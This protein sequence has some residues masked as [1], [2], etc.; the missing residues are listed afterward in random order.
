MHSLEFFEFILRCEES[1]NVLGEDIFTKRMFFP[2]FNPEINNWRDKK[3]LILKDLVKCLHLQLIIIQSENFQ[4]SQTDECV[5]KF[6]QFF[7]WKI[8]LSAT[9]RS[10]VGR[11][12]FLQICFQVVNIYSPRPVKRY[13]YPI[14]SSP[15]NIKAEK[16]TKNDHLLF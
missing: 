2:S 3:M 6:W 13:L 10:K 11:I 15:R 9:K 5:L 7:N 12:F 4:L 8:I 16:L 14:F 1:I